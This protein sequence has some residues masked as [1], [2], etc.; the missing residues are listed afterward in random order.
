M[1]DFLISVLWLILLCGCLLLIRAAGV[2]RYVRT[3]ILRERGIDYYRNNQRKSRLENYLFFGFHK[4]VPKWLYLFMLGFTA[5]GA[6]VVL[7]MFI[8]FAFGAVWLIIT[9]LWLFMY[10]ALFT[11][12]TTLLYDIPNK[13]S[14]RKWGFFGLYGSAIAALP[15]TALLWTICF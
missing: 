7:M 6:L 3:R 13:K 8:G 9:A 1:L 11:L 2:G 14:V 12:I 10:M 5:L 4:D 15:L